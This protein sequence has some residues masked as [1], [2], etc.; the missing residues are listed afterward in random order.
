MRLLEP[1]KDELDKNFDLAQSTEKLISEERDMLQGEAEERVVLFK[2]S[3]DVWDSVINSGELSSFEEAA[4]KSSQAYRKMIEINSVIEKFNEFGDR[5]MYTP[6]MKQ[7]MN[8]YNR[9]KL[10]DVI[11][12]MCSEISDTLMDAR[13]AVDRLIQTECPVCGRRFPT[14]SAM[15]SHVTQKSDPEHQAFQ[16]RIR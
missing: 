6:L 1:L 14:R 10:L 8:R 7:T 3:T 16:D 12:E 11:R 9:E 4:K 2:F 15:K 13:E 5:I